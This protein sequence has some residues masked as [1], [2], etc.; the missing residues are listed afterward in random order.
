MGV[1]VEDYVPIYWQKQGVAFK[2][3]FHGPDATCD[4]WAD[5]LKPETAEVLATYTMG[6]YAGKPAITSNV[7]G[8]GKAF[9]VG[10]YMDAASLAQVLIGIERMATVTLEN[11]R[12]WIWKE[13]TKTAYPAV[14]SRENKLWSRMA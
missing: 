3:M 14:Q 13:L 7:V 6:E 11:R 10:A 2:S 4:L 12:C 5:V 1:T 9:Y 8:K